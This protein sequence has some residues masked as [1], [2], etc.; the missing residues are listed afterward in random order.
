MRNPESD[1]R[2]QSVD[3]AIVKE[4]TNSVFLKLNI[5][6]QKFTAWAEKLNDLKSKSKEYIFKFFSRDDVNDPF[7]ATCDERPSMVSHTLI[8]LS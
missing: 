1:L 7:K 8:T 2:R 3:V 5:Q 6:L 4:G